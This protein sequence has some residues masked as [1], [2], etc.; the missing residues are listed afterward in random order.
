[1]KQKEFCEEGNRRRY[2]CL[3]NAIRSLLLNGEDNFLN[4]LVNIGSFTYIVVEASNV[5]T[6]DG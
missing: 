1:V 2:E 3:K 5:C 4:K 6:G